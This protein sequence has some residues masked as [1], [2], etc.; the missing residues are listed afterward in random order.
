MEKSLPF[1]S[2]ILPTYNVAPYLLQCLDSINSQT[3]QNY[4][5]IIVIDGATDGSYEIALE[6]C[7]MHPRFTVYW[8]ENAGSGPARNAGIAKAKGDFVMFVDP[9]D[10]IERELLER[11]VLGQQDGDYDLVATRRIKALCDNGGKLIKLKPFHYEDRIY[12]GLSSVRNAYFEMLQI[13]V[14]GAPTQKLYKLSVI[15]KF[16]IEFPDLR[17]SQDVVF[18]YRYYTH[19]EKMRLL[20][21]SGYNYR[22]LLKNSSGRSAA[23]YYKTIEFIYGDYKALYESWNMPFPDKNF[24]DFFYEIRVFANLQRCADQKWNVKPLFESPVICHIVEVARPK[25]VVK[26][27]ARFFILKKRFRLLVRFMGVIVWLK[28]K[29]IVR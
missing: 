26:K 2:V 10:W 24:C 22:V 21:Y 9:D 4:E 11:L 1:V 8:Q 23:D 27:I 20:S 15:R 28:Q 7:K 5:V 17:R 3:Y 25:S 19:I 6:Y 16:N 12:E 14:V 29:G 13:G 18:N